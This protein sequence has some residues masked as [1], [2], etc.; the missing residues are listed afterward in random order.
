M[1]ICK[2]IH[3]HL[4]SQREY[5][6][7]DNP[8]KIIK[9]DFCKEENGEIYKN[10]L[11]KNLCYKFATNFT[12][13]IINWKNYTDNEGCDYFNLWVYEKIIN[14]FTVNQEDISQSEIINDIIKLWKE[15]NEYFKDCKF[16]NYSISISNLKNMK[17]LYDY[18]KNYDTLKLRSNTSD[19]E[20]KKYYCSYIKQIDDVYNSV[21]D[22][23]IAPKNAELCKIFKLIE[24]DKKPDT[25]LTEFG[26]ST[27]Y[28]DA[29]LVQGVTSSG[30]DLED[31]L[32]FQESYHSRNSPTDIA[33]KTTFS[34][35]GVSLISSLLA[36][37]VKCISSL[38]ILRFKYYT[39]F[40]NWFRSRILRKYGVGGI[41]YPDESEELLG[42]NSEIEDVIFE[43]DLNVKFHPMIN[44]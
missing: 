23:C 42:N 32:I 19:I 26:C 44:S 34:I 18:S 5:S 12:Y 2:S 30:K 40:G 43:K 35:F 29:S 9:S 16:K 31:T 3:G 1:E 27:E 7:L 10:T 13:L 15:F 14:N 8:D 24:D 39:P 17:Y 36:Y 22:E 21:K 33:L 6:R 41:I 37:R 28:I 4:N 11:F 25:L 20:C 38:K